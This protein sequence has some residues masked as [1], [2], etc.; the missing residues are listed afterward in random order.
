MTVKILVV[1][2]D[3]ELRSI[4]G[5]ALRQGGFLTRWLDRVLPLPQPEKLV[6]RL[7]PSPAALGAMNS[8]EPEPPIIPGSD[9]TT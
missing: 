6:A 1:D 8:C 3:F 9:S 2:D 4:V 5:F 7:L